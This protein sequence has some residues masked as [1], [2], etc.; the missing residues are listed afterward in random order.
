MW[1]KS[2]FFPFCF[3][4]LLVSP[5]HFWKWAVPHSGSVATK[6]TFLLYLL[7]FSSCFFPPLFFLKGDPLWI[8]HFYIVKPSKHNLL[9]SSETNSW[10]IAMFLI[11]C[12]K[13][14]YTSIDVSTNFLYL[15]FLT[16]VLMQFIL[17]IFPTNFSSLRLWSYGIIILMR[18]VDAHKLVMY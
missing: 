6:V 7:S 14:A 2:C 12:V 13:W 8:H 9:T 1:Q 17:L 10:A 18:G 11:R 3:L 4:L 5:I 16:I 15:F